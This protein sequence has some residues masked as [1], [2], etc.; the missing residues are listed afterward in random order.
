MPSQRNIA[1]M[2]AR[3]LHDKAFVLDSHCDTPLLLLRGNKIRERSAEGHVDLERMKEGGINASFFAI[4][5]SNRWDPNAC[6]WHAL[7]LLARTHDFIDENADKIALATTSEQAFKIREEGKIAIFLGMENGGPV[8]KDLSVLRLFYRLGIRYLTLTHAGNNEICDSCATKEKRWNGLSPFGRELIS[9]MNRIGMLIDVAHISDDAFYQVLECSTRPVVSTHSCCRALCDV[10][11]NMTDDMIKA[12]AAKGGVIQI[13]FY[14]AFLDKQYSIDFA[15]LS[16][17]YDA[18][19]DLFKA[20]PVKYGETFRRARLNAMALPRP[21]YKRVVDHIDHAV[22]LAG[23][24]HVGL[25]SDFDGIAT[26]PQ[27]LED[28]S[29]FPVIT[30]EL[31]R[32][33][34]SETAIE[35]ILGRNF[36]RVLDQIKP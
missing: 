26:C 35:G 18:A 19:E 30:E 4:Y 8:H 5:V 15:P 9:E 2:D 29:Y 33:G 20:D 27:G 36:L 31:L 6:T 13:N 12:L 10:P 24:E 7:E 3:A 16:E 21:S 1:T 32:R 28:V 25:G 11:R 22:S 23:P 17:A 34:Y 14:P